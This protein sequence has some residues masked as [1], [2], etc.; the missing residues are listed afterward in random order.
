VVPNPPEAMYFLFLKDY[1]MH[2]MHI[3]LWYLEGTLFLILK[4]IELLFVIRTSISKPITPQVDW[5]KNFNKSLFCNEVPKTVTIG[6]A[7]QRCHFLQTRHLIHFRNNYQLFLHWCVH[8]DHN[9]SFPPS[10]IPALPMIETDSTF[11]KK[12]FLKWF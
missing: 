4:Q 2:N 10:R 1:L 8:L 6:P 3:L 11:S 9:I 12:S 5:W 7:K